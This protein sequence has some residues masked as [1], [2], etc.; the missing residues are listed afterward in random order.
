M[1]AALPEPDEDGDATV[2]LEVPVTV[3]LP[4]VMAVTVEPA[5]GVAAPTGDLYLLGQPTE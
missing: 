3:T 4:A 2:M 5:G 1:S